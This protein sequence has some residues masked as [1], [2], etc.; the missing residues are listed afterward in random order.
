MLNRHRNAYDIIVIGSGIGGLAFASLMAQLAGKKVLVL[1]RHFKL[2]GY[3]HT[4]E[5]GDYRW[6]VGVHYIGK[7]TKGDDCRVLFD[8][9][10]QCGVQWS[11]LPEKF[12]EFNYPD[13]NFSVHANQIVFKTDLIERFPDEAKAIR[14]YFEDVVRVQEWFKLKVFQSMLPEPVKWA[15][16]GTSNSTTAL[17]SQL[18]K[19]YLDSKFKSKELKALLT[20]QWGDCGLPP[21]RSP[22]CLHAMVVTHYFGGGYYPVGSAKSIADSIVPIIRSKGGDCLVNHRVKKIIIEDGEAKGVTVVINHGKTEE[23]IDI[24]APITVSDAGEIVTFNEL[25]SDEFKK[26][27]PV[28]VSDAIC[29]MITLYVGLKSS[30]ADLGFRGENHWIFDSYDHDNMFANDLVSGGSPGGCFLSFP[31]L[32]DPKARAHTAE[33]IAFMRIDAFEAWRDTQWKKRGADYDAFKAQ[34]AQRLVS[35]VEERFPG[36]EDLIDYMELSTPLT[37][38]NF[39]GHHNGAIYGAPSTVNAFV[40]RTHDPRTSIKKLYITGADVVSLGVIGALTGGVVTASHLLGGISGFLKIMNTA[41]GYSIEKQAKVAKAC[42]P[43]LV[44]TGDNR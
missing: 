42:K 13:F 37:V 19:D 25:V 1:E 41:K 26:P 10:T 34:L 28:E 44:T 31:S 9:I 43:Q 7:M 30:P 15:L 27:I 38:N 39:T 14:Q 22:F 8:F 12:D 20:S 2:G 29:S 23:E 21:S 32:K 24:L 3:T 36:F 17:A 18:T 6:D 16:K 5:R 4:F 11:K 40:T 35:F 33:I